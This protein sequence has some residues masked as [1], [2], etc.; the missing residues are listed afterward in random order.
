MELD[1]HLHLEHSLKSVTTISG[2]E[3]VLCRWTV[4]NLEPASQVIH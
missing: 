3:K 1:E 4:A 2:M